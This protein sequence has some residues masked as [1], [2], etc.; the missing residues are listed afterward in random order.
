MVYGRIGKDDITKLI[1]H[2]SINRAHLR[3]DVSCST[4][5]LDFQLLKM[6]GVFIPPR[7]TRVLNLRGGYEVEFSVA[8]G[9]KNCCA[10]FI[11]NFP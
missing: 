10:S 9:C 2:Y 7:W 4:Q 6:Q 5:S 11:K 8:L 1:Q 3:N